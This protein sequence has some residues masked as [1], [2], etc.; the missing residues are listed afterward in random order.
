MFTTLTSVFSV[1]YYLLELRNAMSIY[2]F[3]TYVFIYYTSSSFCQFVM[4]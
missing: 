1:T 2:L 3:F 4:L